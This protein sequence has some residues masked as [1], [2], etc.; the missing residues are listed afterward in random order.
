MPEQGGSGLISP[1]PLAPGTIY[2]AAMDDATDLV[3]RVR[4]AIAGSDGRNDVRILGP[5]PPPLGKLRG[6]YRAQFLLKSTNRK[7]MREALLAVLAKRPDISRRT[8][9]DVDPV[10]T[11]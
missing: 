7:R 4:H 2:T 9:V 1:D 10:S 5:A 6:E 11:L 3:Q 8:T